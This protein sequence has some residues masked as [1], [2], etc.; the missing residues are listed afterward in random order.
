[1]RIES[2]WVWLK[3]EVVQGWSS[4]STSSCPEIEP[5]SQIND[6]IIEIHITPKTKEEK[7]ET[8]LKE[9]NESREKRYREERERTKVKAESTNRKERERQSRLWVV[10][11][12]KKKRTKESRDRTNEHREGRKRE[13]GGMLIFFHRERKTKLGNLYM[14]IEIRG[15]LDEVWSF[16]W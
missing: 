7:R 4:S 6:L 12:E 3:E 10:E 16:V 15:E 14:D 11:T 13:R 5:W 9:R 8:S 1:M 2:E